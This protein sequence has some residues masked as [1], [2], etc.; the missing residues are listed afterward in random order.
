MAGFWKSILLAAILETAAWAS[1]AAEPSPTPATVAALPPQATLGRGARA[2]FVEYEAENGLTNGKIIGPDRTFTSLAAEASG[3]RAVRLEGVGGY[4]EFILDRPA[5]AVSLRYALPDA[6]DGRGLDGQIAIY[7]D[8]VR[9][10]AL[11]LT[12]RYGWFYGRYPFTNQPGDG[13]PHHFYDESRL[14][15]PAVLPA[16]TRVRF[17][18]EKPDA[19]AWRVLD[20][21]DFER[22]GPPARRPPNAISILGFGADPSGARDSLAPITAAIAA[23]RRSGRPVWIDPG[24]YR[25]DGHLVA[26]RVTLAGAGP[27]YSVLTGRG[28]GV[29]GRAAPH[30]S[31]DVVLRDFAIIGEVEERVDKARLAGV[32]G[33]MSR[34][35]IS[36]LWIQH[37]KG[38][39]WFDGPMSAI[40][41]RGLRILD[42]TADGLNFHRDVADA[43]VEDTF[44]RNAGDDGLASW[45]QGKGNRRITFRR[46][47]VIAPVLANGIAAYG[48]RDITIEGNLVA[49]TVTEG[50]GLHLGSRFEATPFGGQIRLTGNTTVRAGVLDPNWRTGVGALW[51]YALDGP[52]DGARIRVEDTDLV[53][54]SY[55]AIQ[56]T[57]KPIRGVSFSRITIDGAGTYAVQLQSSGAATFDRVKSRGLGIGGVHDCGSG[58]EVVRAAGNDGWETTLCPAAGVQGAAR[59]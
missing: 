17:V 51:L 12:S 5:D 48:G 10:G 3:R 43:V 30:G 46:N 39:L 24:V 1:F 42:Q 26:D 40:R 22:V 33:A 27:W 18:V 38:G 4:V 21:A 14:R 44:V 11:A 55:E 29:Y 50:G 6:A 15:L 8:G 9:L 31:R 20:L 45:S 2:P 32:G 52:I 35:A 47:T 56:F 36:N 23:G 57:G 54:S 34:S 16:G 13:R 58:F 37:T 41:V 19:A 25:V 28:V 49:D 59:R 7:A 53:D